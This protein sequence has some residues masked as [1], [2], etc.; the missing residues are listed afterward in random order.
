[1]F[2]TFRR[3]WLV[4]T[5]LCLTIVIGGVVAVAS[6]MN[7][8]TTTKQ[9]LRFRILGYKSDDLDVGAQGRSPGDTFFVQHALWNYDQTARVGRY[10]TACVLE[11]DYGVGSDLTSLNRC[12]ATAFLGTGTVELAGRA[13]RTET[14]KTLRYAVIGGTGTYKNVVGQAT[15]VFGEPD[16]LK[17]E[18]IPSFLRP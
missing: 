5:A 1:M 12:T 15:V 2:R 6:T 8:G 10:D 4:A 3:A 7:E 17:L 14:E 16:T 18:L 11:K 9:V 13:F